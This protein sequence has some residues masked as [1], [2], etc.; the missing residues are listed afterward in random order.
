MEGTERVEAVI[1]VKREQEL[2]IDTWAFIYSDEDHALRQIRITTEQRQ[3][4]RHKF[5]E[6]DA[7][8]WART[9]DRRGLE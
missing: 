2:Q 5:R 3:T 4:K 8:P 9:R 1:K 6:Q 7:A